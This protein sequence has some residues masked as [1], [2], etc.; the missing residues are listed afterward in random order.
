MI[1][2]KVRQNPSAFTSFLKYLFR[3]EV[4]LSLQL[5]YKGFGFKGLEPL[6]DVPNLHTI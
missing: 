6:F 4:V 1:F 3:W 5:D 2:Q